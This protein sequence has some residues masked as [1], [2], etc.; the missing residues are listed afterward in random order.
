MIN[1]GGIDL[2]AVAEVS[3][4]LKPSTVSE[5]V[6]GI[7]V[8]KLENI[9]ALAPFLEQSDLERIIHQVEIGKIPDDVLEDLAPFEEFLCYNYKGVSKYIY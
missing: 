3:A 6:R 8:I 5:I 7:N 2:Q 4:I 1:E 9:R